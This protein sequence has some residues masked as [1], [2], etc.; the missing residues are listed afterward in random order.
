MSCP[1]TKDV[2]LTS[3]EITKFCDLG[4][5]VDCEKELLKLLA[6]KKRGKRSLRR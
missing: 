2:P 5:S 4:C 6:R 1:M 3:K